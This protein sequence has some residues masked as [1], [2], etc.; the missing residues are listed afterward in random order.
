MHVQSQPG[1][2]NE[3]RA[4]LGFIERFGLK[5]GGGGGRRRHRGTK[6]ANKTSISLVKFKS[7]TDILAVCSLHHEFQDN[8]GYIVE[9]L[10]PPPHPPSKKESER[11]ALKCL[12]P[13]NVIQNSIPSTEYQ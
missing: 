12:L 4:I 13:E 8:L 10:S 1:L 9:L 3:F 11:K 7:T 5:Q 2:H 6:R